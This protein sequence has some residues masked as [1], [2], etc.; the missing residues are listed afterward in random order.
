MTTQ[1]KKS[2]SQRYQSYFFFAVPCKR[3][4]TEAIKYISIIL[5]YMKYPK[6]WFI[7]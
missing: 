1:K 2:L 5:N 4:A 7:S 6:H 3:V